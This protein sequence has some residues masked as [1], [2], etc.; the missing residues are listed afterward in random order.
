MGRRGYERIERLWDEREA[1]DPKQE[2]FASS[3]LD[4]HDTIVRRN[5]GMSDKQ[6][7]LASLN[8]KVLTLIVT[9]LRQTPAQDRT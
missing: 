8:L 4:K 3:A 5:L 7:P 6:P 1:V 2:Q 9:Q